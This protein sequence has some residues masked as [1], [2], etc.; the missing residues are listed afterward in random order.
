VD[1][2]KS[3]DGPVTLHLNP[4]QGLETP[5]VVTIPKGKP[6]IEFAVKALPDAQPRKQNWQLL[7]TADVSGFEEELRASPVEIELKKVEPPKVDPKKK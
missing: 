7:A 3:F 1:R 2:L 4:M 6:S 5:E